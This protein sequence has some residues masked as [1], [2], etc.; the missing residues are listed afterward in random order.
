MDKIKIAYKVVTMGHKSLGLR[1]NPTIL[2]FPTRQ[3]VKSPT[4][5]ANKDDDGGIWVAKNK[6]GAKRLQNYMADRYDI[7][8]L[9]FE[10]QINK[11]LYKNN[12]RIKTDK[13]KLI[14]GV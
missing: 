12:Y 9:I 7:E 4:I 10:C 3:W 8:T 1:K 6:S 5:K 13:V 2:H 14:K 11:I